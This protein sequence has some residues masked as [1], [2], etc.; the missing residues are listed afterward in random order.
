MINVVRM[1]C[2]RGLSEF[3]LGVG[4]AR[5]RRLFC[6]EIEPLFDTFRPLTARGSIAV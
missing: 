3:D 4:E 6:T 1:C 2:Q 5:F